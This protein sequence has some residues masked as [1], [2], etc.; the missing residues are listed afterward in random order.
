[1][2]VQIDRFHAETLEA[3][4]AGVANVLRLA[5]DAEEATRFRI[6]HVSEFRGEDHLLAPIANGPANELLVVAD[7]VHVG[8]VEKVHADLDGAM[9]CPDR[10]RFI[11]RTIN[12]LIPM[13]PRPMAETESP[14]RP[15]VR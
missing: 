9:N 8:G 13:Q 5:I 14:E 3:G 11:G 7:A 4:V 12:S 1:L 6:A 2:V 10:F 15:R